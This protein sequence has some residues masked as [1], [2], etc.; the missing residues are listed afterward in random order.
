[1]KVLL[2]YPKFPADTF[3][4]FERALALSG[5][6]STMP[7]LGLLTVAGMLPPDRF[8]LTLADENVRPISDEEIANADVVM[9]SAMVAQLR[10]MEVLLERCRRIGTPVIMGGPL[11]SGCFR[12]LRD[13]GWEPTTWFVGEAERLLPELVLDLEAGCLQRVYAHVTDE[14]RARQVRET[15]DADARVLVEPLP[16]LDLTPTPRF[17]LVEQRHY[18][19]MAIQASRGCPIGCEFCDIWK[20]FGLKSRR[21]QAEHV[22]TQLDALLALGWRGRVFIVDDNFIGNVGAARDLLP[23]LAEWQHAAGSPF[24]FSTEADVRIGDQA[25]KMTAI[26]NAMVEAGFNS[27]FLGIETPSAGALREAGKQVNIGKEECAVTGLLKRVRTIQGAGM[28][29]MSGFIIG[30][31][32][33]PRDIDEAMIEFIERS[34]IPMAMVGLL[35]VVPGTALQE[36][37]EQEGRYRG[38]L[39]GAQ[40]HDFT[41]NYDPLGRSE[42]VVLEQYARVLEAVYGGKMESYYRRCERTMDALP[43]PPHTGDRIG[44]REVGALVLS[45]WRVR[46][47][48][49]YWRF[50]MRTLLR[51][52]RFLGLAVVLALQGEHFH[53]LTVQRLR[54]FRARR[55]IVTDPARQTDAP[56]TASQTGAA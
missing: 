15:L 25:P 28:E 26:R 20:Q 53:H 38:R 1:M 30:F 31:D 7:P 22:I 21:S 50:L 36:R 41:L 23:Q 5:R 43:A 24:A 47:R 48:R 46:P 56:L 17:D 19:S 10:S 4:S 45:L 11:V 39:L 35:G 8:E 49:A 13:R 51:R 27:V 33:D 44:L 55:D 42:H 16:S 12:E 9:A 32:N 2:A 6:C 54:E 52:P 37:L 18:H 29:V 34:G 40:T 3:W 14:N